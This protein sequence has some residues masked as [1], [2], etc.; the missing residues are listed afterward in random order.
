MD[1]FAT[2]SME[3]LR[4]YLYQEARLLDEKRWDEWSALFVE[5]GKYWVPAS[6]NQPDPLNHVSI[7]YE[8]DLLRAVR[9]KRYTH[10]NAL[11]LQ[12]EPH[13]I[14]QIS[15]VMLDEFDPDSG[16]CIVNSRLVMIEYRRDE[17]FVY[18]A[19]VTHTLEPFDESWKIQQK[20]V[21]LVNCDGAL[22]SIQIYF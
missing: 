19:S 20:K 15:N 14:H 3:A 10:P 6:R 21:E 11:S 17:Q 4:Q 22:D 8:G 9:L 13:S 18:G 16:I 1:K 2:P 7:M 12:P 5:D